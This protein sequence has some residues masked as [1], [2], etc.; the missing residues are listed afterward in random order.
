MLAQGGHCNDARWANVFADCSP[1]VP[2]GS[3]QLKRSESGADKDAARSSGTT[4]LDVAAED[5]HLEVV[6]L[7]LKPRKATWKSTMPDPRDPSTFSGMVI[8]DTQTCRF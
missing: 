1:L 7:L 3:V 5:G 4:A 2:P 6:P 8:G